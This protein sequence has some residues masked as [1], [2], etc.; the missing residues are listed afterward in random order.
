MFGDK[1]LVAP[2]VAASEKG[3]KVYLPKGDHWYFLN[4]DGSDYTEKDG[5]FT[6]RKT[7][8]LK[9]GQSVYRECLHDDV[10]P[11]AVKAGSLI[12]FIDATVDT[13]R[14][15]AT[16]EVVSLSE[17]SQLIYLW[18]FSNVDNEIPQQVADGVH[19]EMKKNTQNNNYDSWTVSFKDQKKGENRV[20]IMQIVI[21]QENFHSN[22]IGLSR[23]SEALNR[24]EMWST[25]FEAPG[26]SSLIYSMDHDSGVLFVRFG[27]R[28]WRDELGNYQF[29]IRSSL[30][31]DP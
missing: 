22:F 15:D 14:D 13:V 3:R 7:P 23:G 28:S 20:I 24:E 21:N 4:G 5:R 8:I 2:V 9:G 16:D 6:A 19:F 27:G 17:R 29:E 25:N 31:L 26:K 1:L 18:A 12:P 30:P 10:A 11:F